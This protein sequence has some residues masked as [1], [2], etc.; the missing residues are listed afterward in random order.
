[1]S[2]FTCRSQNIAWKT[3]KFTSTEHDYMSKW[4]INKMVSHVILFSSLPYKPHKVAKASFMG[5]RTW[6]LS[7][8]WQAMPSYCVICCSYLNDYVFWTLAFQ[9]APVSSL[10]HLKP[11][12]V[13]ILTQAWISSD[14]WILMVSIYCYLLWPKVL[15]KFEFCPLKWW[16]TGCKDHT[17][18]RT[19]LPVWS[20]TSPFLPKVLPWWLEF[21]SF[22]RAYIYLR[23]RVNFLLHTT[24]KSRNCTNHARTAP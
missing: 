9:P 20:L 18:L 13:F 17:T 3:G 8:V 19:F 21:P 4:F 16:K 5:K 14:L 10:L 23:R 2:C 6:N 24:Y 12:F 11:I 7:K 1:M 22:H 15:P